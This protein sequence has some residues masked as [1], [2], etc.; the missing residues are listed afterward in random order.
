MLRN[1]NQ[2]ELLYRFLTILQRLAIVLLGLRRDGR[3]AGRIAAA[4]DRLYRASHR[5]PGRPA[6]QRRHDARDGRRARRDRPAAR[7]RRAEPRAE[8]LD[9][10]R[11]LVA[12]R[13]PGD[14]R[15]GLGEPRERPLGGGT[16]EFRYNAEGWLYDMNLVDLATGAADEPHGDRPRQLL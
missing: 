3:G 9:A 16:Q 12:G 10:V 13:T 6:C 7:R 4:A 2:H 1:G 15:P 5:S 14:R 8:Y 11:G